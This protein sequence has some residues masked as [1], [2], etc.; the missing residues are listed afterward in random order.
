MMLSLRSDMGYPEEMNTVIFIPLTVEDRVTA[1]RSLALQGCNAEEIAVTLSIPLKDVRSL[2][3]QNSIEFSRKVQVGDISREIAEL[4]EQGLTFAQMAQK[5]NVS[6]TT[7]RKRAKQIGITTAGQ[8]KPDSG[9]APSQPRTSDAR[10]DRLVRVME[11]FEQGVRPADIAR[12]LGCTIDMIR[13]DY[14][15]LGI[16][17]KEAKKARDADTSEKI[18]ALAAQ[19]KIASEIASALKITGQ[20]VKLLA[21]QFDIVLPRL[22]VAEHGTFLS[23]RRGCNCEQCRAANTATALTQKNIRKQKE[24]PKELHGTH[25]G[26]QNWGCHCEPC[27]AAGA[28]QHQ[29]ATKLDVPSARK[30]AQWTQEE[31]RIVVDYSMTA[32][33]LALKLGRTVSAVNMR[34]A[35]ISARTAR[36]V[37]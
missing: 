22:R 16:S 32:R 34:R 12:E 29:L 13:S 9:D 2:A 18:R 28:L 5:L 15:L 10:T 4:A 31:D 35:A 27:K 8:K 19:G 26:Y 3:R 21:N 33:E 7:V 6:D 36:D 11:L 30:W 14:A 37:I 1:I 20:R 24:M 23:Y 25:N 17:A